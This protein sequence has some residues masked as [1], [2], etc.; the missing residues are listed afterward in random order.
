M[1]Y[2]CFQFFNELDI[3]QLRLHIM[4][5]VVDKFVIS[6]STVTFSGDPKPLFYEENKEMFREFEDKIIHVVVE[7]TPMD[8]D[9]YERDHHQKCAVARGRA[10]AKDDDIIIFSD[11]DEIPDPET[12]RALLPKV[13]EGKIY[14]LAQRLFYCYLNLEDVSGNQLSVTGEFPGAEPKMW[15]GT[16]IC[17]KSLLA[18][19]TTEELRNKEQQAIGVR[20]PDGGWH[21]SY[22]GGGKGVSVEERVRYKIK[23]AAH[24]NYNTRRTLFE[25]GARLRRKEDI[26]GREGKMVVTK[27]D[28]SYPKYLRDHLEEYEYLLYKEPKWY[29]TLMDR[30]AEWALDLR[31]SLRNGRS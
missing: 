28:E 8:C 2:D 24:Q 29:Q 21:F 7:D 27:I 17:R 20:V 1:V 22:M 25:V 30:I 10:D 19:Y 4:N 3:L 13:E 12:V 16:K 6:E 31:A 18:Q 9:A 15:L 11:V 23:S 26:L 5:D 14:M